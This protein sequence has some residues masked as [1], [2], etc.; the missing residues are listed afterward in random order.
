LSKAMIFNI[1]SQFCSDLF[2]RSY[3]RIEITIK[4]IKSE[5]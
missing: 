4:L 5:V 3:C 1:V 2:C